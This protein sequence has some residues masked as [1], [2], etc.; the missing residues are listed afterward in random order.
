[1]SFYIIIT[2]KPDPLLSAGPEI[3]LE[4]WRKFALQQADFRVPNEADV[5]A[6]SP[7]P[8]ESDLIWI[9]NPDCPTVWFVWSD[10]QVQVNYAD[11]CT[12]SRMQ[13]LAEG[14]GAYV[15]SEMGQGFDQNGKSAGWRID[16][17][18]PLPRPKGRPPWRKA[19]LWERLLERIAAARRGKK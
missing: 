17:D 8:D 15:I 13:E 10:G 6:G 16:P 19:T 1:M 11:E 3:G 12:I 18:R 7:S 4:E 9:G 14:L 2:R 5:E